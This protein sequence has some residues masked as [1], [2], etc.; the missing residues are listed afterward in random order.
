MSGTSHLKSCNFGTLGKCFAIAYTK[1]QRVR[2]VTSDEIELLSLRSKLAS[3]DIRDICSHHE[4]VYLHKYFE[5]QKKC[6][7][8][9]DLHRD[10][11]PR[12]KSLRVITIECRASALEMGISLVPGE[13]LC[14]LCRTHLQKLSVQAPEELPTVV[15]VPFP[16]PGPSTSGLNEELPTAMSA[17]TES[18]SDDSVTHVIDTDEVIQ[19]LNLSPVKLGKTRSMCN[20]G[21]CVDLFIYC[22]W[23]E[24]YSAVTSSSRQVSQGI[25]CPQEKAGGVLPDII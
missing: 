23:S 21:S 1:V 16:G 17:S 13:K 25:S 18:T 2:N 11:K 15:D 19:Y 5:L 8:A 12:K 20:K 6:C 22:R 3:T 7:N 9:F 10:S 14:P 24:Q 4:Q